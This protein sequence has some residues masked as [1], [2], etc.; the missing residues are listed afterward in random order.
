MERWCGRV[1]LVT[2]AS[3]G[4]GFKIASVLVKS[5]MTVVGAAR[6]AEKV[7]VGK[8]FDKFYTRSTVLLNIREKLK[9]ISFLATFKKSYSKKTRKKQQT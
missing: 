6:R 1:A 5:G 7:Q 3:S 4:I 9:I 2:G 8:D